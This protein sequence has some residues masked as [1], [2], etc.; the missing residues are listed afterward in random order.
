MCITYDDG[1]GGGERESGI[2]VKYSSA[3]SCNF[4]KGSNYKSVN[5]HIVIK[6]EFY[7]YHCLV[8]LET[9]LMNSNVVYGN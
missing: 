5:Y 6:D 3:I 2:G 8:V 1:F 4:S 9:Y 7:S